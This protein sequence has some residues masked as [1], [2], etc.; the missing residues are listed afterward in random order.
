MEITSK[1]EP[2]TEVWEDIDIIYPGGQLL[3]LTIKP[4]DTLTEDEELFIVNY[5]T[6]MRTA[7][8]LHTALSITRNS[9]T[10]T[11]PPVEPD[12]AHRPT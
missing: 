3:E 12:A 4:G 6:G 2:K 10:V 1:T 9:R 5:A 8:R 11:L 7:I